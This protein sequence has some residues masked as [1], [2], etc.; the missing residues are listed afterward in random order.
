M[1]PTVRAYNIMTCVD[2]MLM[3]YGKSMDDFVTFML[4]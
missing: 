3:A 2:H 1:E 4:I